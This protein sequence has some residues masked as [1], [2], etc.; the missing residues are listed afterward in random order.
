MLDLLLL[1]LK[2]SISSVVLYDLTDAILFVTVGE[3]FL[4]KA[5]Y[6]VP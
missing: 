5:F 2:R 1:G 6:G 3:A 4:S